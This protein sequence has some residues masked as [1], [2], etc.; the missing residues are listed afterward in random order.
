[1]KNAA[2]LIGF[3]AILAFIGLCFSACD[4]PK[5]EPDPVF[6]EL[7]ALTGT[8]SITGTTQ[9]GKMLTANISALGGSG[10]ISFEWERDYSNTIGS[11]GTYMVQE[12]DVGSTI[13]V[14]VTLI[15]QYTRSTA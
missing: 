11:N 5:S 15:K 13:T 7:P 10:T 14:T 3:I 2:K 12:S 6:N 4:E 1:M 8:V 9:V